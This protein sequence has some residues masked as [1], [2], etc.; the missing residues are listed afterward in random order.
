MPIMFWNGQILFD[1][2][3]GQIAMDPSCCCGECCC[4]LLAQTLTATV[5]SAD[6][7]LVD[8]QV[9]TL[10]PAGSSPPSICGTHTGQSD[11]L[12]PCT[13][14]SFSMSLEL[15]CNQSLEDRGGGF[16]DFYEMRVIYDS[17][18]CANTSTDWRRVET[19]CDCSPLSLVFKL[20][21]PSW[22]GFGSPDCDCCAGAA[23][24]TVTVTL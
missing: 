10:T 15:R 11:E 2:A 17:S 1:D 23:D 5:Y 24:I 7:A 8:G 3:S 19:G 16:C 21:P 12:G 20:P 9:I 13:T 4:N 18:S 22:G 14:A 6:C